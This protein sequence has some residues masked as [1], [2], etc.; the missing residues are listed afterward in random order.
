ML[1][2]WLWTCRIGEE[3]AK[4]LVHRLALATVHSIGQGRDARERFL[5]TRANPQ[6][7]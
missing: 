6:Q 5:A 3:Y 7:R 4:R 1:M 2:P